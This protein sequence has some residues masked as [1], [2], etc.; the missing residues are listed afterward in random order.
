MERSNLFKCLHSYTSLQN[1]RCFLSHKKNK[2]ILIVFCMLNSSITLVSFC[3]ARF[4][5]DTHFKLEENVYVLNNLQ[6]CPTRT[7]NNKTLCN[8]AANRAQEQ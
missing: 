4:S 1:V 3:H 2:V 5:S 6:Q 8:R 7:G